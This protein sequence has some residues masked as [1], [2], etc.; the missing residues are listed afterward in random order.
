MGV[1][2]CIY[3]YRQNINLSIPACRFY[4]VTCVYTQNTEKNIVTLAK[5]EFGNALKYS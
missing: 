5:F 4:F 2:V 3:T 1:C